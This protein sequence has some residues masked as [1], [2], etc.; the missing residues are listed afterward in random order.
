VMDSVLIGLEDFDRWISRL[1][2]SSISGS[3]I[4]S[5]HLSP[6]LDQFSKCTTHSSLSL[7]F[8]SHVSCILACSDHPRIFF[9]LI[10]QSLR[11]F[12][13]SNTQIQSVLLKSTNFL[14]NSFYLISIILAYENL[15][16]VE[17]NKLSPN[18]LFSTTH[19]A[20][21]TSSLDT[22]NCVQFLQVLSQNQQETSDLLKLSWNQGNLFDYFTRSI[23]KTSCSV[24][25]NQWNTDD[26][27]ILI[28]HS[29]EATLFSVHL[30]T[31]NTKSW[32][33]LLTK[34]VL[35][36]LYEYNENRQNCGIYLLE[37]LIESLSFHVSVEIETEF[38]AISNPI[39]NAI[40]NG[41]VAACSDAGSGNR[42]NVFR[43]IQTLEK[44]HRFVHRMNQKSLEKSTIL[45]C[46]SL[47]NVCD[48]Q[49]WNSC[50]IHDESH[51]VI[52][53]VLIRF[54][55]WIVMLIESHY[56]PIV[57]YR[58]FSLFASV[59]AMVIERSAVICTACSR[60]SCDKSGEELI[61]NVFRNGI[62]FVKICWPLLAMEGE[63]VEGVSEFIGAVFA[64]VGLVESERSLECVIEN[65]SNLIVEIAMCGLKCRAWV[66]HLLDL[67]GDEDVEL[68]RT[69]V[70]GNFKRLYAK[71]KMK[72]EQRNQVRDGVMED[73]LRWEIETKQ[74]LYPLSYESNTKHEYL[75]KS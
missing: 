69:L 57:V 49:R 52:E 75:E 59:L 40:Q 9:P 19:H 56:G 10:T 6:L 47:M 11:S 2:D 26:I 13:N 71:Y 37:S 30:L 50:G 48:S 21:S 24:D 33:I 22:Q 62:Q 53:Q 12:I 18:H 66:E 60:S 35:N 65:G 70:E 36:I 3:D 28:F 20:L 63:R 31:L 44:F 58:K 43:R 64:C 5:L 15:Q 72:M 16:R 51:R 54:H 68:D 32:Q 17:P 29:L 4:F 27:F 55:D 7:A 23:R 61:E 14:S 45:V 8:N 73:R 46:D 39:L 42:F 41:F 34:F 74:K 1:N 38:V 25:N 67:V